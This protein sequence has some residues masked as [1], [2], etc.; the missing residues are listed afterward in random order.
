[1]FALA[2]LIQWNWQDKF[3]EKQFVLVLGGLHIEMAALK[4]LGN[5]LEGSGWTTALVQA[6]IM[7]SG[8]ADAMLHASHVTRCRHAHQVTA[9]CLYIL[10]QRAYKRYLDSVNIGVA[11]DF[12][13]WCSDQS[14]KQPQFHYW[15]LTLQFEL[16]VLLFVKSVRESNFNLYMSALSQIIPKFFLPLITIT[17]LVGSSS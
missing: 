17:M 6:D 2:K 11:V 12:T 9:A 10:Q 8:K 14:N 13:T 1:M 15:A 16:N 4:T 3:G 5:W 7:S